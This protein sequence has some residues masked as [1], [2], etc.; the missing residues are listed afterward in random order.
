MWKF[1]KWKSGCFVDSHHIFTHCHNC[2]RVN[3]VSSRVWAL[4]TTL[5]PLSQRCS[6]LLPDPTPSFLPV[7]SA[8][9][10]RVGRH[11]A[12]MNAMLGTRHV[13][14]VLHSFTVFGMDNTL[15]QD[16][17]RPSFNKQS[18]STASVWWM[19]LWT[20]PNSKWGHLVQMSDFCTLHS[21]HCQASP[22]GLARDT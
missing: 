2:Q 16:V 21:T 4:I 9:A 3:W 1:L 6:P 13:T 5:T 10:P 7:W 12:M 11:L 18:P 15:R 17:L 22:A 19:I 8:A 20:I 14:N